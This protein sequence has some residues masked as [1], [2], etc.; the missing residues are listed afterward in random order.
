MQIWSGAQFEYLPKVSLG[1]FR[2]DVLKVLT[3]VRGT[4][5]D[6]S[7]K[8]H[9][10]YCAWQEAAQLLDL[11]KCE[12]FDVSSVSN[13]LGSEWREIS[14]GQRDFNACEYTRLFSFSRSHYNLQLQVPTRIHIGLRFYAC[15][16][17]LKQQ[18]KLSI[19]KTKR[20]MKQHN[21]RYY[22][23]LRVQ[24]NCI[25]IRHIFCSTNAFLSFVSVIISH[26]AKIIQSIKFHYIATCDV[27]TT[28]KFHSLIT[29]TFSYVNVKCNAQ[30]FA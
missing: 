29:H 14:Q 1:T 17:N 23:Y 27:H 10:Y 8:K 28:L 12:A 20:Q 22:F 11:R 21:G 3:H 25:N 4:R 6:G 9:F 16:V 19:S 2:N 7:S 18:V 5:V 30:G 13:R 24:L 15:A 26:A